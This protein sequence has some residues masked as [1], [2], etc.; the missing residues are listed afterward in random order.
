[1]VKVLACCRQVP[2][3][4][5]NQCWTIS[6]AIMSQLV[7]HKYVRNHRVISHESPLSLE[8]PLL[9]KQYQEFKSVMMSDPS[10]NWCL[11]SDLWTLLQELHHHLTNKIVCNWTIH[12]WHMMTWTHFPHYWPFYAETPPVPG[13]FP[14]QRASNAEIDDFFVVSL[15]KLLNKQM[16]RW[17]I[18][19]YHW[20]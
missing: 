6:R 14:A 15:D 2:S 12:H 16:I 17:R 18:W 9:V 20:G 19:P 8:G 10:I 3:H 11:T 13:G 7:G 4:N 5:L 1:M